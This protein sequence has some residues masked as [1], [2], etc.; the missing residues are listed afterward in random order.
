[1][2]FSVGG[3]E[4]S[5]WRKIRLDSQISKNASREF[6]IAWRSQDRVVGG[7]HDLTTRR[8]LLDNTAKSNNHGVLPEY[9]S[10]NT[11]HRSG[12]VSTESMGA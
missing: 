11:F 2:A 5:C 8:A 6:E 7:C 10:F 4:W 9:L 3:W 1:M 12:H